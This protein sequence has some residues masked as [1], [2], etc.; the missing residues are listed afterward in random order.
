[1]SKIIKPNHVMVDLETMGLPTAG[2]GRV[3]I[4]SIGAVHFDPRTGF[5]DEKDTFYTELNWEDQELDY[6][7][8]IT[9]STQE[10]W[11][12]QSAQAKRALYGTKDLE[13]GI[14]EFFSWFEQK[15]PMD[16]KVWGNGPTFDIVILEAAAAACEHELPWKFFNV[17][18]CRTIN[19][20]YYCKHGL[21]S[22]GKK[23]SHNALEDALLQ[24]K[25]VN[26]QWRDLM[27]LNAAQRNTG[28]GP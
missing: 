11:E 22:N 9:P 27:G 25:Q 16:G 3:A 10:W 2:D 23:P 18:D 6:D 7:M 13:T 14:G 28:G 15:C 12:K 4:V 17:R 21:L 5:I 8:K 19:D 24:A 26:Q 1:M 20:M